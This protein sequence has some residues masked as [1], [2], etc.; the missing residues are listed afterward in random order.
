VFNVKDQD[1]T[2]KS[3]AQS[4]MREVVGKSQLDD[5]LTRSRAAV[6][7]D[8]QELMQRMLDSY[9]AGVQVVSVQIKTAQPPQLVNDAFQD[10]IKA[11]QDQVTKRNDATAYANDVVPKAG[12]Q[13]SAMLQ[14]AEAYRERAVR[15]AEGEAARFTS[16]LTEYRKAPGVTRQR[17]YLETMER[18]YGGADKM[19]IDGRT[20]TVPYL[21]LDQLRQRQTQAPTP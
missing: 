3:V 6:E 14:D 13:A 10:V 2:V 1:E 7:Q 18:V 21:S 15:E 20:G 16:V 8:T 11:G 19:I 5:V 17:L 12:G 9:H 4:A